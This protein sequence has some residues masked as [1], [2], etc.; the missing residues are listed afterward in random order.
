MAHQQYYDAWMGGKTVTQITD[1]T[2]KARSTVITYINRGVRAASKAERAR[3]RARADLDVDKVVRL[4]NV[5]ERAYYSEGS[6][7]EAV[8][9]WCR[10]NLSRKAALD[11]DLISRGI[12]K[13]L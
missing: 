2:S 13:H 1:E 9:D 10:R 6:G 4:R 8:I 3:I 11:W 12:S 7:D 5:M